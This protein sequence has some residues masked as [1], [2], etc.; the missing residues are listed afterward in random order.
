M[1][2]KNSSKL[3]FEYSREGKKGY[4]LPQLDVPEVDIE[5]V[6]PER[7]LRKK[8]AQLPEVSEPEII[9]HFINLSRKNYSVDTG[10]YPLGSCTMKYNPK[11]NEKMSSLKGFKELHPFALEENCQGA[12]QIMYEL[13]D[14][15]SKI[16][17]MDAVTL[18]P[19]AG[20]QGE[21]CGTMII[22]AYFKDK[23]EKR[24]EIIIPDSAHGTNPASAALAGMKVRTVKSS[25][26][27]ELDIDELEKAIT[28]ATAA[29][30]I[31]NPNTLGFFESGIQKI[32]SM[33]HKN[34]SLL[35]M[36]GANL[37]AMLGFLKPG[38]MGFDI[39]HFNLHKSFSTP[40]GCGGPGA[41]PVGVKK[42]LSDFLPVPRIV[43]KGNHFHF[44]WE[45][46]KSIGR[47]HSFYGNFLV[48][49][50]AYVYLL[51]VGEKGLREISENAIL[52]A[53]YLKE[54]L[55]NYYELPYDRKCMHEFVLSGSKQKKKGVKTL[56][57][58][59]RLMDYGF[60]PPTIYFPL[61]VN[62][63][64]M[65]EPTE[66]ESI[67][68]LDE[69]IEA[70]IKIAEESE[71]EPEIVKNAPHSLSISRLDEVKAAKQ[72]DLNYYARKQ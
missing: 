53:N 34:G 4:S 51:S 6:V 36:D 24:D 22:R 19:S 66:T 70:M 28:P 21:L 67:E 50:R 54:S 69:F 33:L 57:I 43:R 32:S 20:A 52:N 60:H 8:P 17:G 9:R 26:K 5:K 30:M 25:E 11:I 58:A 38:D 56:D 23:G 18:Q 40:H 65:I 16:S 7:L 13:S 68:T 15:L 2:E 14:M 62:E 71:T 12:L 59:K 27:G 29:L 45:Q 49:V 1:S 41:G 37:N 35:Y 47:L 10:F 48:M 72:L 63:A 46:K 44:D 31:T 55:K 64:L 39:V 42:E 61:I 3:I